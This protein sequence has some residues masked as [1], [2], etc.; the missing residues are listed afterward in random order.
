[1]AVRILYK[2]LD[3]EGGAAMLYNSNLMFT[4]S[5]QLNDPFDCHPSLIDYSNAPPLIAAPWD[6]KTIE[7]LQVNHAENTRN[8]TWICSLSKTYNSLLMWSYYNKHQGICVGIDMKKVKPYL[9]RVIGT[10]IGCPELEVKYKNIVKKPNFYKDKEDY[11]TYQF[12]TKAKEW[13]HEQEVRLISLNPSPRFMKL[14][15]WQDGEKGPIDW[16]E[17]RAFVDLGG[18][19]FHS[20]YLGVSIEKHKK[21]K[22]VE[23]AKKTNPNIKIYQMTTDPKAFK[24]KA[25][26]I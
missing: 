1:M 10:F 24:L 2:Y 4:N 7:N 25:E 20:L 21:K 13:E 14:M 5:T 15:P 22:I 19:C 8:N 16:K 12:V 11:F 3:A 23:F 17:V 6:R 18:E 26:Q 9:D